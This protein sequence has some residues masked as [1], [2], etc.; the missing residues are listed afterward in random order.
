[1]VDDEEGLRRIARRALEMSGYQVTAAADGAEAL[2]IF[3]DRGSQFALV[4]TDLS[5]PNLDGMGLFRA[6][7]DEGG[8]VPF[9]FISGHAEEDV[10]RASS[11][12]ATEVLQKPWT[13]ADLTARVK[14]ILGEQSG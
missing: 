1:M 10:I 6:V 14:K 7:H 2:Q 4:V 8:R 11:G 3:R 13:V 5:M 9:L 12:M